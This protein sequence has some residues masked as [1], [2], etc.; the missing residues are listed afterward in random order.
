MRLQKCVQVAVGLVAG[1]SVVIL[2]SGSAFA[3]SN[4]K[5]TVI[6]N[7]QTKSVST[8]T[9]SSTTLPPVGP[10][11][12]DGQS[13]GGVADSTGGGGQ[14]PADVDTT[15]N[16]TGPVSS[17]NVTTVVQ[18]SDTVVQSNTATTATPAGAGKTDSGS[19]SS[20]GASAGQTQTGP[21]NSESISA[22]SLSAEVAVVAP[23]SSPATAVPAQRTMML[24][25]QP[26]ITNRAADLQ[27]DLAATVPTAPAPARAP[28]PAKSSGVLGALV[29]DM[30]SVLVP[31]PLVP[32]AGVAH[33][34]ALP[35]TFVALVVLLMNVFVFSFGLWLRRG[36]FVTAARSDSPMRGV[37]SS[38]ATP[39]LLGY[40]TSP[41]DSHN[42][43]LMVAETK[44]R[45]QLPVM[46]LRKEVM[47]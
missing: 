13:G 42:P 22:P 46:L 17:D 30:A 32:W 37:S 28:T 47:R 15:G 40:V 14:Q 20:A 34:I 39:L 31:Q 1:S 16:V 27:Q 4:S 44:I 41:P 10:V 5:D 43:I 7:G 8:T 12:R 23:V 29:V 11:G 2:L 18:T 36:G 25:I 3:A 38:F 6:Q 21:V 35:V 19:G 26:V 9:M 45:N 24:R 33:R